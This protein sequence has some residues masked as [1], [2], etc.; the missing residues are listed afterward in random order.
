MVIMSY[1]IEEGKYDFKPI[2]ITIEI[3]S[4]SDI[5]RL[6]EIITKGTDK[7]DVFTYHTEIVKDLKLLQRELFL[8]KSKYK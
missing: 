6:D 5:N 2:K 1:T 8:I 4:L 3:N 7:K